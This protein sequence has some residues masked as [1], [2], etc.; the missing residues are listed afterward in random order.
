MAPILH[1]ISIGLI[2]ISDELRNKMQLEEGMKIQFVR[3]GDRTYIRVT[4]SQIGL[5][6][7]TNR[8]CKSLFV[9]SRSD[10]QQILKVGNVP[11]KSKYEL[12]QTPE[13][14]GGVDHWELFTK[15]P[16]KTK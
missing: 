5:I 15:K 3:K 6:I 14:I 9:C 1:I 10:A 2:R 11:E 4:E 7:H 16:I 13:Q 12:A 8:R